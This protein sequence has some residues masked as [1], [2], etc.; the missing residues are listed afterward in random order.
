MKPVR[1]IVIAQNNDNQSYIS[2]DSYPNDIDRF[3][4][5]VEEAVSIN[6]WATSETPTNLNVI[7][8][9]TNKV[10]RM[11]FVLLDAKRE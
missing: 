10:C 4:T 3:I 8:D 2:E 9:P 5:E 11:M 6:L 1:R 7:S